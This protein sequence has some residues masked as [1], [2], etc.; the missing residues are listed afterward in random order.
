MLHGLQE[1][2][3]T[4]G[5]RMIYSNVTSYHRS[6]SMSC[7]AMSLAVDYTVQ[8]DSTVETVAEIFT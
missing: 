8:S 2:R 1:M 7:F 6:Y 5:R 4:L 3:L